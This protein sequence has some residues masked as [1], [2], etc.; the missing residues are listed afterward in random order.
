MGGPRLLFHRAIHISETSV[1]F[2]PNNEASL[3]FG[4]VSR[5]PRAH[6]DHVQKH[7]VVA[8]VVLSVSNLASQSGTLTHAERLRLWWTVLLS[9][10]TVETDLSSVE[11]PAEL[12][13]A[14]WPV[15]DERELLRRMEAAEARGRDG[16]LRES[17]H[18]VPVLSVKRFVHK[19][20]DRRAMLGVVWMPLYKQ[21][22]LHWS[23]KRLHSQFIPEPLLVTLLRQ[24]I[25]GLLALHASTGTYLPYLTMEN[26]LISHEENEQPTFLLVPFVAQLLRLE[27]TPMDSLISFSFLPPECLTQPRRSLNN[28][29]SLVWSLGML[30]HQL[31]SGV[32]R[33]GAAVV[34]ARHDSMRKKFERPLN[35]PLLS[36]SDV[37]RY[38]RRDLQRGPYSNILIHLIVLM[39]GQDPR[40]R[41]TLQLLDGMLF[42]FLRYKPIVRF[43][44]SVGP[45]DLL[46]LSHPAEVVIHPQRKRY[47]FKATCVICKVERNSE[48]CLNA[49]HLLG[50]CSPLWSG[51]EMLPAYVVERPHSCM[52][53]LFPPTARLEERKQLHYTKSALQSGAID[54]NALLQ[55]FGGFAVVQMM[56]GGRLMTH[57][58]LVPTPHL[59]LRNEELRGVAT[60]LHFTAAL[61]WPSHCTA[62][63]EVSGRIIQG[64]PTMFG[65]P[66]AC[67]YAWLLPGERLQLNGKEWIPA[68]DGGFVFWF[69][70]ALKPT[71]SDRY[72]VLC[73]MRSLTLKAKVESTVLPDLVFDRDAKA[74][75]AQLFYGSA[76]APAGIPS[77]EKENWSRSHCAASHKAALRRRSIHGATVEIP[78]SS[79]VADPFSE[80]VPVQLGRCDKKGPKPAPEERSPSRALRRLRP[81]SMRPTQLRVDSVTDVSRNPL[82]ERQVNACKLLRGPASTPS[83]TT[84][85][86][87][88]EK[89]EDVE[90]RQDFYKRAKRT[91]HRLAAVVEN[92]RRGLA[93]GAQRRQERP[94]FPSQAVPGGSQSI[95]SD[96]SLSAFVSPA[97]AVSVPDVDVTQLLKSPPVEPGRQSRGDASS[98]EVFGRWFPPSWVDAVFQSLTFCIP[99]TGEHGRLSVPVTVSAAMRLA[100]HATAGAVAMAFCTNEVPIIRR[101][102]QRCAN[103][104]PPKQL[105][106]LLP[107]HGLVFY[108]VH[109]EVV[110]LLALRFT[111]P[112]DPN[113]AAGE[114]RIQFKT[115][116]P[117]P[118]TPTRMSQL[119]AGYFAGEVGF[120][121]TNQAWRHAQ[122]DGCGFLRQSPSKS[123]GTPMVAPAAGSEE[124]TL[125][126]IQLFP[127][128]DP[129]PAVGSSD[130]GPLPLCWVGFDP[131][132]QA[133]MLA[134][135]RQDAWYPLYFA[136]DE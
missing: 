88:E 14:K 63:L 122:G 60:R 58:V 131:S 96:D 59:M 72:F 51:D 117:T 78:W 53:Y 115:L 76:T 99:A 89:E 65:V 132:T 5:V 57:E 19:D 85:S 34:G 106:C 67:W 64:V 104:L 120:C 11:V 123:C 98:L 47:V 130:A 50:P 42:D 55:L 54:Q 79:E 112:A 18:V 113:L 22:L 82:K 111:V 135:L 128:L 52:T 83:P 29:R 3:D 49:E 41:S 24:L 27:D 10:G 25:T 100:T 16:A 38:V 90:W 109:R 118:T 92:S 121:P 4:T 46:R 32:L 127:S 48:R 36:P 136:V 73:G 95:G 45:L 35:H 97:A 71:A 13:D 116:P 133:M 134:D 33:N 2:T 1:F 20:Q 125:S 66:S 70:E 9:S 56:E 91:N 8:K 23:E 21:N 7:G 28:A 80:E 17:P 15:L 129:S 110:G 86:Q 62:Q 69:D 68:T 93:S 114:K 84:A 105:K 81:L 77:G 39:L 61:P 6:R 87:G 44:F 107:H 30:L 126:G 75:E 102:H 103:A 74:Y 108:D 43:P 94:P 124:L 101:N 12:G 119:N 26:V 37:V 40:T 31:A